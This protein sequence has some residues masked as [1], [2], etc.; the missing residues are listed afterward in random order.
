V[1]TF[2]VPSL[3]VQ[4][5]ELYSYPGACRVCMLNTAYPLVK[6]CSL[7]S[8]ATAMCVF[9]HKYFRLRNYVPWSK[10][11]TADTSSRRSTGASTRRSQIL[12]PASS[13]SNLRQMAR[14]TGRNAV[15]IMLPVCL[16]V[17]GTLYA[18]EWQHALW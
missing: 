5:T 1:C 12:D 13:P 11:P 3:L 8:N 16:C 14:C 2:V 15:R 10:R 17:P 9:A 6:S 4:Q 7:P 18:V